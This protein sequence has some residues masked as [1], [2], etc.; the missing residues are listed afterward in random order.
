M[1]CELPD[2]V[3]L[4][5]PVYPVITFGACSQSK[6][7]NYAMPILPAVLMDW[8]SNRY[9]R[10]AEDLEN[11]L[12]CPLRRNE[13]ELAKVCRT[14][15]ITAEYDVLRDE[16]LKYVQALKAAGVAVTHKQY[17]NTV[18]GFFGNAA[19]THGSQALIDAAQV[20]SDHF[21]QF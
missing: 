14:H 2:I 7:E 13:Q 19:I 11:P 6:V 12:V 5:I 10:G 3:K 16:G 8:F 21:A 18:H 4:S 20:I 17:N 1:A 9:F 15:V